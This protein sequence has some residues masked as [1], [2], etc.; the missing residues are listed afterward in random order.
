[1]RE[2][3]VI[4]RLLLLDMTGY[5]SISLDITRDTSF[6][7]L[8]SLFCTCNTMTGNLV[9]SDGL[10][11]HPAF[12]TYNLPL[13]IPTLIDAVRASTLC[14]LCTDIRR[15]STSSL[16][17][18]READTLNM[19]VLRCHGEPFLSPNTC[20]SW[21]WRRCQSQFSARQQRQ[22]AQRGHESY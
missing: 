21:T 2:L 9:I 8:L 13:I 17:L 14:D 3:E 15:L 22:S 16:E 7:C 5:Y 1:M 10:K 19:L 18:C 20:I 6:A 4:A 12:P 11:N